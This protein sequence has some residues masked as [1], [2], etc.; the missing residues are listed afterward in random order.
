MNIVMNLQAKKLEIVQLVLNTEKPALLR[1]VEDV[2]KKEET[3]DWWD[4]ISDA[5][6]EAIEQGIAEA[7]RGETIPHE[8]VMKE[9]KARYNLD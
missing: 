5:E 3:T 4:E 6:R 2:L 8:V 9:V 1:K 7:D